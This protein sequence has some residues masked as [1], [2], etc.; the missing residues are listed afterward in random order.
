MRNVN[1]FRY[2][3]DI[4]LMPES[5]EELKNILMSM[6]EENEKVCLKLNIKKK[7]DHG[8]QSHHFM[9][10]RREKSGRYNIF[11]FLGLKNH[12]SQ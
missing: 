10:N 5:E 11:Y 9:A 2:A 12:C 1:N 7:D 6:E 8:S 4:T 3:N